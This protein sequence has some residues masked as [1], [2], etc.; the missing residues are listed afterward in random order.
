MTCP[1]RF[2]D[3]TLRRPELSSAPPGLQ[4]VNAGPGLVRK[5][6]DM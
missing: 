5:A 3:S 6:L 4:A 1:N 2:I